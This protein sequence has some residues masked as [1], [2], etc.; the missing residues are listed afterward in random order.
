VSDAASCLPN[1]CPG[2]PAPGVDV[3][4]CL[5]DDSGPECEDRT[6]DD[7]AAQGGTVIDA[8]SC[9]GNPCAPTPPG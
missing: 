1:P 8:T 2:A 7:C 3:V 6:A 5:P 4:C 9:I